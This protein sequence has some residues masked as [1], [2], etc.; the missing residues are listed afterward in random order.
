MTA[1][2]N[3]LFVISEAMIR[4]NATSSLALWPTMYVGLAKSLEE[5]GHQCHFVV[6][7]F[8]RAGALVQ[9]QLEAASL[10]VTAVRRNS[11]DGVGDLASAL[12][13][14]ALARASHG[15]GGDDGDLETGL[16]VD[17]TAGKRSV[18]VSTYFEQHFVSEAIRLL[19]V[20]ADFR[21]TTIVAGENSLH[22]AAPAG[23]KYDAPLLLVETS[24]PLLSMSSK[25]KRET[26]Q[27][28]KCH[29]AVYIHGALREKKQV[30]LANLLVKCLALGKP[31]T[32]N[33]WKKMKHYL[34][35][36]YLTSEL[37]FC[38]ETELSSLRDLKDQSEFCF[39]F[40]F[41]AS[42]CRK[43]V[44]NTCASAASVLAEGEAVEAA[45]VPSEL[46]S[47]DSSHELSR[48]SSS[49]PLEQF[50]AFG[51]PVIGIWIDVQAIASQLGAKTPRQLKQCIKEVSQLVLGAL[52]DL[53]FKALVLH[54]SQESDRNSFETGL[55]LLDD[56]S[57]LSHSDVLDFAEEHVKEV[58]VGSPREAIKVLSRCKAIVHNGN[59]SNI[60]AVS[61]LGIPSVIIPTPYFAKGLE[62]DY[63]TAQLALQEHHLAK[64]LE[65]LG[66]A[67]VTCA[68]A[69]LSRLV[70]A[71]HLRRAA[72][73]EGMNLKALDL[74]RKL[75]A[76][77]SLAD[78]V[79]LIEDTIREFCVISDQ[80][81]TAEEGVESVSSSYLYLSCDDL[82]RQGVTTGSINCSKHVYN[83]PYFLRLEWTVREGEDKFRF[84]SLKGHGQLA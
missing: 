72:Q 68:F 56:D 45:I 57:L 83:I 16:W 55:E 70:L 63:K 10:S 62:V 71:T 13:R 40:L 78:A 80:A 84:K 77:D 37:N 69:S 73:D 2:Q 81:K 20:C 39:D 50:L 25:Y 79:S 44:F 31:F 49:L 4:D 60:T 15:D 42:F 24:G 6:S 61:H 82:Q 64:T 51:A 27:L 28:S 66:T 32:G 29:Q 74:A 54:Y 18:T 58:T 67:T 75:G 22:L 9:R 47:P 33:E 21:P 1:R 76:K 12:A 36:M 34:K 43:R 48:S 26:P 8:D 46:E 53:Q 3:I 30:E 52:A 7:S 23:L 41:G 5:R 38:P 19:M 35:K 59:L 17:P 14:E 11:R 65:A